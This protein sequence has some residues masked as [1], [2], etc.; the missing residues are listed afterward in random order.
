VLNRLLRLEMAGYLAAE[1][2]LTYTLAMLRARLALGAVSSLAA[3]FVVASLAPTSAR[4]PLALGGLLLA[5]FI[6]VHYGLW[7]KFPIWYHYGVFGIARAVR[8]TGGAPEQAQKNT[9]AALNRAWPAMHLGAFAT[10]QTWHRSKRRPLTLETAA[11]R[12]Y[13]SLTMPSRTRSAV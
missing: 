8:G 5:V 9:D 4:L 3:G 1:S 13:V 2:T 10:T 7:Q 12:W 11:V 6:P